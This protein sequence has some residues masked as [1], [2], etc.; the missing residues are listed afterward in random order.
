MCELSE[1]EKLRAMPIIL[2]GHALDY[3]SSKI[4][5]Q[6]S[7]YDQCC[8][9][10]TE[11]YT[12]EEKWGRLLQQWQSIHLSTMMKENDDKS[13]VYVLKLLTAKLSTI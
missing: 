7:S 5:P 4:L 10:V 13:Q 2:D 9:K 8:R 6:S 1:E 3:F 11:H 12:S